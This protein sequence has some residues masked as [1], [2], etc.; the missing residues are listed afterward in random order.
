ML[1]LTSQKQRK[2]SRLYLRYRR[3]RRQFWVGVVVFVFVVYQMIKALSVGGRLRWV[4]RYRDCYAREAGVVWREAPIADLETSR[5]HQLDYQIAET[6]QKICMTT[7]T[8]RQSKSFSQRFWRCRNFDAINTF[9]NHQNY[10]SRH[11][12]VWRDGSDMIDPSRPPAWSKIKA[13]EK[14][15]SEAYRCD[16]IW[17]ID[18]DAVIMKSDVSLRRGCCPPIPTFTSL[19]HMIENSPTILARG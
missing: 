19:P 2:P 5:V 1:P 4:I 3:H 16:W 9:A 12:Y 18:A 14:L 15:M 13:V 10:A 11:N 7:L 8:D 6:P 17:W